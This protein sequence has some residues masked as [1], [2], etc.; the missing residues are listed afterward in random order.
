VAEVADAESPEGKPG[1]SREFQG[2]FAGDGPGNEG[3]GE[4]A[5]KELTVVWTTVNFRRPNKSPLTLA[6]SPSDGERERFQYVRGRSGEGACASAE[7]EFVPIKWSV[8]VHRH[9][10]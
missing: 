8:V 1:C 7:E 2:V 9:F 6:L 3:G 4:D 5:V 10:G